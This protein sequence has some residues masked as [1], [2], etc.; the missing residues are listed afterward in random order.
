M[1][2]RMN[3]DERGSDRCSPEGL[4]HN[5]CMRA[6]SIRQPFAEL[7]LRGIKKVEYRSRRTRI[8]GERFLIYACRGSG[9]RGQGSALRQA[10]DR[11]RTSNVQLRTSNVERGKNAE[12]R[13]RW[14]LD[15]GRSK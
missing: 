10:Q 6:L 5:A 15:V 7:I 11:E 3:A 8:V 12:D 1:K 14:T 9:A 2:P 4:H 13:L